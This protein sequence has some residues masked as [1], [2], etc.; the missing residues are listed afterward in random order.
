MSR[1][2]KNLV[3]SDIP[4]IG[5]AAVGLRV[6]E[7]VAGGLHTVYF[8]FAAMPVVVTN[9]TGA[10]FGSQQLYTYQQGRIYNLGGYTQFTRIDWAGQIADGGS[11]DYSIGTTASSDATL[12]GTDVDIQA[13]TAMLDPFVSGIGTGSGVF[14]APAAFDG[15]TTAKEAHFNVI[16]DDADVGDTDVDTILF[17]GTGKLVYVHFGDI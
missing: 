15:T 17:T 12:A 10:S 16:V 2:A 7:V 8:E 4:G 13:S 1:N 14:A 3:G 6:R 9:V 11:G 5:A